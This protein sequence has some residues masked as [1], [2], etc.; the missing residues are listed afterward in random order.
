MRVAYL[1]S[2]CLLSHGKCGGTYLPTFCKYGSH[3][4]R[5]NGHRNA[6]SDVSVGGEGWKCFGD[7]TVVQKVSNSGPTSR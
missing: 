4:F 7:S 5:P 1:Q 2:W 3:K 6:G